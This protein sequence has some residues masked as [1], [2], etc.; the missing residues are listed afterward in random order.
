MLR[1]FKKSGIIIQKPKL[2]NKMMLREVKLQ[3]VG[4]YKQALKD[5]ISIY[6]ISYIEFRWG[7]EHFISPLFLNL[8]WTNF[9]SRVD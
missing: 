2:S 5:I 1:L 7:G 4:V 8:E 6:I 3:T 9:G